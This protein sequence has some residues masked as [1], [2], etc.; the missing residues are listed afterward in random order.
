MSKATDLSEW[1][2]ENYPID[3]MTVTRKLKYGVGKNDADYIVSPVIGSNQ[4]ACPAY[5]TW[6]QMITRA[7]SIKYQD[8]NPTY[9]DVTVCNDWLIFSNFRK[10]FIEN[11]V[12]GYELDKDL[13]IIGN[14]EYSPTSCVF[15]P[16]WINAFTTDCAAKRGKYKIGVHW[17]ICNKS[18]RARC[19]NPKTK[20]RE[21]LGLFKS[22]NEA[23]NAWLKRKLEITF[24]LKPEMDVIDLRIYQSIVK[25]I[26]NIF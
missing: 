19:S 12:D 5:N 14:R 23:H 10:W 8:K 26:N 6:A 21:H 24:E 2:R 3:N 13:L 7:Y 11:H 25:I 15:V 16:N 18:F 1:L 22:E 4:I 9:K 20:Q 17:D